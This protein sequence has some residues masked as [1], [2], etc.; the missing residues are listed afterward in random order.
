MLLTNS[1]VDTDLQRKRDLWTLW[2]ISQ[3]VGNCH[4]SPRVVLGECQSLT[5]ALTSERGLSDRECQAVWNCRLSMPPVFVTVTS[6]VCLGLGFAVLSRS[7]Q[8]GQLWRQ[9]CC[10]P[11]S[12]REIRLTLPPALLYSACQTLLCPLWTQKMSM[13]RSALFLW[14][15]QWSMFTKLQIVA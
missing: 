7:D 13:N 8:K 12:H 3:N 5:S 1:R 4:N 9:I 10:D 14:S 2:Y 6:L 15:G 11:A